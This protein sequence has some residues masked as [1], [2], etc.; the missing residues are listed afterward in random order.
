MPLDTI[1][2][3]QAITKFHLILIL[4]QWLCLNIVGIIVVWVTKIFK[5]KYQLKLKKTHN[6]PYLL[7]A[8]SSDPLKNLNQISE[9]SSDIVETLT[10]NIKNNLNLES[11]IE[12][13]VYLDKHMVLEKE[14]EDYSL[15]ILGRI[16]CLFTISTSRV[17]KLVRDTWLMS[18]EVG[19]KKF[20]ARLNVHIYKF[21]SEIDIMRIKDY[22]PWVLDGY[23]VVLIEIP[24][25]GF[26]FGVAINMDYELFIV[27]MCRIPTQFL[28]TAA[29][30]FMASAVGELCG[31][32]EPMGLSSE[33]ETIKMLIK[34]NVT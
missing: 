21:G 31:F 22:G 26:Q 24:E 11:A 25:I 10:V 32:A 12:P 13:I 33:H 28:I 7:M 20:R 16:C 15:S 8:S 29:Y 30:R 23:L 17:K 6:F 3:F 1:I 9:S 5:Y 4:F 14:K 27:F 2:D 18:R 19:I 34:I